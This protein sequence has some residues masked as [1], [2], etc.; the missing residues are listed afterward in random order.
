MTDKIKFCP[1]CNGCLFDDMMTCCVCGYQFTKQEDDLVPLDA[2]GHVEEWAEGENELK[3]EV[4]K[5]PHDNK[6]ERKLEGESVSMTIDCGHCQ[7]EISIHP[8]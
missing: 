5:M 8:K 1:Q 2:Y 6:I 7:I 3:Q 4:D